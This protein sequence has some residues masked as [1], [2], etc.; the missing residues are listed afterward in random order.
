M[1]FSVAQNRMSFGHLYYYIYVKCRY[2]ELYNAHIGCA[3]QIEIEVIFI[4][5]YGN[6]KIR[7]VLKAIFYGDFLIR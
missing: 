4:I 6:G 3:F 7:Y 5:L 1:H 2:K